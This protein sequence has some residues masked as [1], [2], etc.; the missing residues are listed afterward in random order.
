MTTPAPGLVGPDYLVE[1]LDESAAITKDDV[2]ALWAQEGAV[3]DDEAPRRVHEVLVVGS[4]VP[5]GALAAVASA[6]LQ[7][8]A[9][10]RMDFWHLRTFVASDHRRTNLAANVAEEAA[11]TLRRRWGGGEDRRGQGI[12]VEVE[13]EGVRRHFPQALWGR[14][15]RYGIFLDELPDGTHVRV[16][17]FPG[18]VVPLP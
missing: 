18:A 5:S 3:P 1:L 7:R 8:N 15:G 13:N 2:V 10:L 16:E 17:Y 4:H 11:E 9:K 14:E 12:V 6:F